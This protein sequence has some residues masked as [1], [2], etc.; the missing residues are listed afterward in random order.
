VSIS[1]FGVASARLIV[2]RHDLTE[3]TRDMAKRGSEDLKKLAALQATA[4][5]IGSRLRFTFR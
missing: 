3:S 1:Q 5:G 2:N 4:V